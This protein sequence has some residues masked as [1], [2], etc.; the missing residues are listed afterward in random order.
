LGNTEGWNP[1]NRNDQSYT[2][3]LNASWM[4]GTHEIRF[5]FDFLHHLMNHWQPE[6]GD[7]PRGAFSFGSA[8][9][10]LNTA[11]LAASG[12][13]QGSTPNFE[14]GWNSFAGFLLG[15]PTHSGKSSQYIKMNSFENVYG[16]FIRDRWRVSSKL[17]LN[18][19]LRWE[20]YPT[21][22]RS[23]GMGIESY[24][25]TTNEVLVGGRGGIPRDVGVGYSKKLFAPRV[26]FAYQLDKNTVIRSGY[27]L[28]IHSHPW[29][30]QAL[31]GW[32][33][34]TIVAV[35]DGINGYEPVTTD[36]TY[37]RAGVRTNL[38]APAWAFRPF[39]ARILTR[40]G[41]PCR[42]SAIW[43]TRW[44]TSS[45]TAVTS[46]P[47]TSSSSGNCRARSSHRQATSARRR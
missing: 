43:V 25:P 9:T 42:Q 34:L 8:I 46:S 23:A 14:N 26:G 40:G 1:E 3:N 31:R 27:G 21:R 44:P 11:A 17:T 45:C 38:W 24:D 37:V 41:F 47:G 33:P 16:L 12:G 5:G 7:G 32:Y 19:G 35:F 20:L 13:F 22:T 6:L 28:T 39:A 10:S 30:A 4:K 15:T 18:L 2:F 29:G 36:P